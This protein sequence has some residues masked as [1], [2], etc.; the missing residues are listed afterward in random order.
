MARIQSRTRSA[1]DS[2]LDCNDAA[3]GIAQLGYRLGWLTLVS[4]AS[5][6]V[7]VAVESVRVNPDLLHADRSLSIG[8]SPQLS[9]PP[10][11]SGRHGYARGSSHL[12]A[13]WLTGCSGRSW[14]RSNTPHQA[15]STGEITRCSQHNLAPLPRA[16]R[17]VALSRCTS[18]RSAGPAGD[19]PS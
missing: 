8:G 12:F 5:G 9:A 7:P 11:R 18:W 3:I 17:H 1:A 16:Y 19:G 14:P 10:T 15:P 13:Q 2:T 6:S 4:L